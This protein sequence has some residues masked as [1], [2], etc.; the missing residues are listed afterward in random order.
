MWVWRCD[1]CLEP[2]PGPQEQGPTAQTRGTDKHSPGSRL[3]AGRAE[4]EEELCSAGRVSTSKSECP[5]KAGPL[6]CPPGKELHQVQG[7]GPTGL[8]ELPGEGLRLHADQGFRS[9][10]RPGS[11]GVISLCLLWS[12]REAWPDAEL[13]APKWGVPTTSETLPSQPQGPPFSTSLWRVLSAEKPF[14]V[15]AVLGS[16]P[17]PRRPWPS[18]WGLGDALSGPGSSEQ[19]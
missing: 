7:V 6:Q 17:T 13:A 2:H 5:Q 1:F 12:L 19:G 4:S 9:R 16:V 8:T 18:G 11:K 10:A 15:A 14:Q 3:D